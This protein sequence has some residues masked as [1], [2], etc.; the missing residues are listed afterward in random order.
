MTFDSRA[1]HEIADRLVVAA[2]RL[3]RWLKAADPSPRLTS[4]QASALAVVVYSGGIRPS[5]LATM[6]EVKRPTIARTIGELS[7]MGFV[8]RAR[9]TADGR[10]VLVRATDLGARILA[11][12]QARRASPL[13]ARLATRPASELRRVA[14]AV[15]VLE[16]VLND[17]LTGED[18]QA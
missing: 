8:E 2:V 10:S 3:T 11:E 1:T 9:E 5:D 6:E 14:E 15:R 12:G 7:Q 13:A 18:R 17:A 16:A 4:A